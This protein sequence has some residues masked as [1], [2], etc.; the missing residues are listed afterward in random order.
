MATPMSHFKH[1]RHQGDHEPVEIRSFA[2]V[3]V[4]GTSLSIPWV[5]SQILCLQQPQLQQHLLTEQARVRVNTGEPGSGL[6]STST[7]AWLEPMP[8]G[9][10][11]ATCPSR[12]LF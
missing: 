4:P 6:C 5:K 1:C 8:W 12:C 11:A 10:L 2:S 7:Q 9:C 3:S